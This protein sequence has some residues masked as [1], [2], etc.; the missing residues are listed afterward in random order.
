MIGCLNASGNDEFA[1]RNDV[2]I[3][4]DYKMCLSNPIRQDEF[5]EPIQIPA[6]NWHFKQ[7]A[8][9]LLEEAFKILNTPEKVE[10]QAKSIFENK[11]S[12]LSKEHGKI[13]AKC[14]KMN[15]VEGTKRALCYHYNFL[16]RIV[17]VVDKWTT[18]KRAWAEFVDKNRIVELIKILPLHG[19]EVASWLDSKCNL[20]ENSERIVEELINSDREMNI[21]HA[22]N[23]ARMIMKSSLFR[24]FLCNDFDNL[25]ANAKPRL[26]KLMGSVELMR[27]EEQF[28]EILRIELMSQ[29]TIL[30]S[31]RQMFSNGIEKRKMI[32]G[33]I[34]LKQ[35]ETELRTWKMRKCET[36][37]LQHP[38]ISHYVDK[39][40]GKKYMEDILALLE[41]NKRARILQLLAENGAK[42]ILIEFIG[43]KHFDEL[44]ES[45]QLIEIFP[46]YEFQ[47]DQT[48][49]DNYEKTLSDKSASGIQSKI[50]ADLFVFLRWLHQQI[51]VERNMQNLWNQMHKFF[52]LKYDALFVEDTENEILDK[53]LEI[54]SK[55]EQEL[56]KSKWTTIIDKAMEKAKQFDG[57]QLDEFINKMHQKEILA[58]LQQKDIK[59]KFLKILSDQNIERFALFVDLDKLYEDYKKLHGTDENKD[60]DNKQFL[61]IKEAP[62][63]PTKKL[64]KPNSKNRGIL[65]KGQ[66]IS[67]EFA[68]DSKNEKEMTIDD[69]VESYGC[70]D[71]KLTQQQLAKIDEEKNDE[72]GLVAYHTFEYHVKR[73]L[74][75]STSNEL[76]KQI[77]Y[78]EFIND[79]ELLSIQN[80]DYVLWLNQ[81]CGNANVAE[82]VVSR[83]CSNSTQI[84]AITS[85]AFQTLLTRSKLLR[86][87]FCN[88]DANNVAASVNGTDHSV[89][90]QMDTAKMKLIELVGVVKVM[91]IEEHFP[92]VMRI[93][94]LLTQTQI[95][96]YVNIFS[97]KTHTDLGKAWASRIVIPM[98]INHINNALE[99][100][101]YLPMSDAELNETL[102][103][104]LL[105][106]Y[107][108]VYKG[109]AKS[110]L[111]Y[112]WM[113][114][115]VC[116]LVNFKKLVMNTFALEKAA[117]DRINL[118]TIRKWMPNC[119]T[120]EAQDKAYQQQ[121]EDLA[122]THRK[123]LVVLIEENEEFSEFIRQTP[124]AKTRLSKLLDTAENYEIFMG[125]CVKLSQNTE[126]FTDKWLLNLYMD[127]LDNFKT[128]DEET[129]LAHILA[130]SYAVWVRWMDG[131]IAPE[132]PHLPIGLRQIY[133]Q[134]W[135][136]K[137]SDF[138]HV[139]DKI[140]DEEI[141][142]L[143]FGFEIIREVFDKVKEFVESKRNEKNLEKLGLKI[144]KSDGKKQISNQQNEKSLKL[145]DEWAE[146]WQKGKRMQGKKEEEMERN[147]ELSE[148]VQSLHFNALMDL[149]ENKSMRD[150]LKNELKNGQGNVEK[151]LLQ[152][153]GLEMTVKMMQLI[154]LNDEQFAVM[155][156]EQKEKRGNSE[157]K[158]IYEEKY[159]KIENEWEEEKKEKEK[160][161]DQKKKKKKQN[162]KS[163]W[164]KKDK[165]QKIIEK[166]E[167]ETAT[168]QTKT[169]GADSELAQTPPSGKKLN[170]I[171]D[172]DDTKLDNAL[173]K[174]NI[175][176]FLNGYYLLTNYVEFLMHPNKLGSN[177][178][179]QNANL[180]NQFL[181]H[182]KQWQK[183]LEQQRIDRFS[184]IQHRN[185]LLL[186]SNLPNVE[187]E[188]TV[189]THSFIFPQFNQQLF[190][191]Q[192]EDGN[193]LNQILIENNY[194]KTEESD[195]ALNELKTIVS[196]WS[197]DARLLETGSFMLGANTSHS[198]VDVICIVPEK[199]TKLQEMS[200]FFGTFECDLALRNCEKG[201]LY[202]LLCQH[203]GVEFL[204]KLPFAYIPLI[205]LKFCGIEFDVL[206]VS[207]PSIDALPEEPMTRSD[208]MAIIRKLAIQ[209]KPDEK[210]IKSLA[211]H[212]TNDYILTQLGKKK[213]QYFRKFLIILKFW[214]TSN[215]IYNPIFGFFNG[216]SLAV[217]AT[218]LILFYPNA[219]V[220]FLLDKFFL[221]FAS[222]NWPIPV[223]LAEY[224]PNEF[225]KFSWTPKDEEDKKKASLLM[226][227][228]TPGCLEQNGMYNVN[229]STFNIIQKSMQEALFKV[230][231]IQSSTENWTQLFPIKKF[232]KKY[233]HYVAICCIV[234]SSIHLENFCGYVERRIRLQLLH[235]DNMTNEVS[236]SHLRTEI[237]GKFDCPNSILELSEPEFRSLHKAWLD[238]YLQGSYQPVVLISK[239]VEKTE[240]E[241][242]QLFD[243]Q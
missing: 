204:Q 114:Q 88:L 127:F 109:V 77:L 43:K 52:N 67:K 132:N 2:A 128:L 237:D 59:A 166:S 231:Q 162:S 12:K 177:L 31:Y 212:L 240:V 130:L 190:Y 223:R 64:K 120:N 209:S 224:V 102:S 42:T 73:D 91:N 19:M 153:M 221:T 107:R 27:L 199:T 14:A 90:N 123:V 101:K 58:M 129:T 75:S 196:K 243:V 125:N 22:E 15:G 148:W 3:I 39:E 219:S 220:P 4:N 138:K 215:Y 80:M 50:V 142:G 189:H 226:P 32:M 55:Y 230:R 208:V 40:L 154:K 156:A 48:L 112:G 87:H 195:K 86:A 137:R 49:W 16:A 6:A 134:I 158:K 95:T 8:S 98:F 131:Q 187:T 136:Q 63:N 140:Y 85:V 97:H 218:K 233:E 167:E 198:D 146:I 65:R 139:F 66:K 200:K 188:E 145:L 35:L 152:F 79:D 155:L 41:G 181:I 108:E 227:I 213:I 118:E 25:K 149:L 168:T 216:I 60:D 78:E 122:L 96:F 18:D 194:V 13:E 29:S 45:V 236:F 185:Y 157:E 51:L 121:H 76:N 10:N 106:I 34:P 28:P 74:T 37:E 92:E 126:V 94:A 164:K 17:G 179:K 103:L 180:L 53:M 191:D 211:G 61:N 11:L 68:N 143:K 210:M 26:E 206:F 100:N 184:T 160:I 197:R 214:A 30:E 71:K 104:K 93:D 165:A 205:K 170:V 150:Q 242:A 36:V 175:N 192:N 144:R 176:D 229:K 228:I 38:T 72:N 232:T 20:Q 70:P 161:N 69:Y 135:K 173:Q 183:I 241:D 238:D 163:N 9:E 46:S 117:K 124:G 81:K 239:Y 119:S 115:S 182:L 84:N 54:E 24:N 62:P 202:C 193:Q 225:K 33:K 201:S 105:E 1:L 21:V 222:W 234:G 82:R 147:I 44:D 169:S 171:I 89:W 159:K 116:F 133:E 7:L 47:N 217:M 235:F 83:L 23:V 99:E 151:W 57:P 172:D 203:D 111:F 178:K 141:K 186:N 5:H 113:G 56:L 174:I 207:I 110:H